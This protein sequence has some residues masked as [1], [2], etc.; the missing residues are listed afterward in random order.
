M[1]AEED[2]ELTIQTMRSAV[3]S[4]MD[5]AIKSPAI[6]SEEY[7]DSLIFLAGE[8]EKIEWYARSRRANAHADA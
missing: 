1:S 7:G 4:I 3:G 5:A 8:L 6:I 2:L